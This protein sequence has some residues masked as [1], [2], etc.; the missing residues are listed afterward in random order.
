[1]TVEQKKQFSVILSEL[2]KSL[3]ITESQYNTVVKSYTAV[4]SWL[5]NDSSL[6]ASY[7]P[8]ILPQG[9][10]LLG[11]VI[12]PIN[13]NDDIDIDLVCKLNGKKPDWTQ[14]DLKR[15]VGEQLM[16]NETYKKMLSK[17]G[18][19]CW[20]LKYSETTNYHMDI[21]PSIASVGYKLIL[22]KAFSASEKEIQITPIS[23]TD[24]EHMGYKTIKTPER[25]L[26][27]NPFEYARWFQNQAIVDHIIKGFS[28]NE[29]IQPVP[30]YQENKLPLQRV[31]QI[32]KRHRDMMFNGDEDKPIS[33]IITTLAAK[34]YQK[35]INIFDALNNI[36]QRIPSFI[37]KKDGQKWVENPVN[38]SENFADKWIENKKKEENFYKWLIQIKKD[39]SDAS[40]F[41]GLH[42]IQ[43][44]LSKSFG[45]NII[46]KTFSNYALIQKDL[47][48]N[49]KLYMSSVTGTLSQSG[50]INVKNHNFFGNE[51]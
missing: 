46:Q 45:N 5:A 3:D 16:S 38:P 2:G 29:A 20:T 48:E 18:R 8:E 41:S 32:L 27:S 49:Q 11:L 51:K 7:Q 26:Q 6:L 14:C 23:I 42:N 28:L 24:K 44:S 9:S 33:I 17:E 40:S 1:M 36:I 10:F 31:I 13:P 34:A 50:S 30:E 37:E 25:W 4:G 15:I 43:E 21:L 19:R 47:R 39:I 12:Q 35:E 22:E